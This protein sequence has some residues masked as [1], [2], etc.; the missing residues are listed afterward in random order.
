MGRRNVTNVP[1]QALVMMNDP[2]VAEQATLWAKRTLA[3][4][5]LPPEAAIDRM[6]REAFA[7]PPEPAETATAL[8]FL[9]VQTQAHGGD[10]T[11][12]PRQQAAWADLAHA[13]FNAKEFIFV[14]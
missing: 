10:F 5:K 6:Y 9:A 12:D 3:D 11:K 2:F 4:A 14:P 8:E 7:R 13:L 1:A